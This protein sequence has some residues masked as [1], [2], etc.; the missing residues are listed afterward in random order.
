MLGLRG[1]GEQPTFSLLWRN[2]G[3]WWRG[4]GAERVE[5]GRKLAFGS[6]CRRS[7]LFLNLS[8]DKG[9]E[10]V[11]FSAVQGPSACECGGSRH[12]L[13]KQPR[14]GGRRHNGCFTGNCSV[15]GQRLETFNSGFLM[16]LFSEV[17]FKCLFFIPFL[18][19]I[20]KVSPVEYFSLW[21][22]RLF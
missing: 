3:L 7:S 18:L 10:R 4:K 22:Q 6:S 12:H 1:L 13:R 20:V 19:M 5:T 21:S 17:V 11:A 2:L 16:I 9:L 8:C 15:P 14:A